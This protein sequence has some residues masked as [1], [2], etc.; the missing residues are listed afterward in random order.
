[1]LS[2]SDEH[3]TVPSPINGDSELP[4]YIVILG[5]VPETTLS[6]RTLEIRKKALGVYKKSDQDRSYFEHTLHK[7]VAIW[8]NPSN[9]EGLCIGWKSDRSKPDAGVGWIMDAQGNWS[10]GVCDG[11]VAA[12]NI[13]L[14]HVTDPLQTCTRY[15]DKKLECFEKTINK[16]IKHR[17]RS[18][19]D[20]FVNG[21]M[22]G[23][24]F[25]QLRDLQM[26]DERTSTNSKL[27]CLKRKVSDYDNCM[28]K[29][30]KLKQDI[31]DG[32]NALA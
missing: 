22:S 16:R 12:P 4:D 13:R 15:I 7:D 17:I 5:D 32:L 25:E 31:D 3:V 11:W 24:E 19:Y 8:E 1:M 14:M 20:R 9:C 30:S 6:S 27:E 28:L 18:A 10:M 21:D 26:Q 2:E 23:C 29:V